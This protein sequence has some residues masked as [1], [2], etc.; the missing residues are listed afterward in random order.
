[1]FTGI[2]QE[3]GT[4]V[5]AE[6]TGTVRRL[7]FAAPRVVECARDGD[8]IAVDGVCLTVVARDA[9]GFVAEAVPVTLERSTLGSLGPGARVNLERALA[10]GDTLGG[11]IV[12]GHV[13][14]VAE[15]V[16]FRREGESALLDV[17]VPAEVS[18]VTV[19]RGSIALAGV[20]LTVS[21]LPAAGVVRVA[22][23]PFTL[24]HT[25]LG[26]L[27]PGNRLNVE[28]DVLAK[29]VAEQTKR[30]LDARAA[31]GAADVNTGL[32]ALGGTYGIR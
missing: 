15:V 12:Q 13:D 10:A 9:A 7:T 32:G 25:T 28:A 4:L 29:L 31:D 1:M 18:R 30:W 3:V 21:E 5:A 27:E 8:S 24:A 6:Q 26:A 20:S 19:V 2:V 11:H 17:A 14:G 22:L 23:V 16:A